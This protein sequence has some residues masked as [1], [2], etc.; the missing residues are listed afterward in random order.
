MADPQ[1]PRNPESDR[2]TS[3]GDAG[4]P[5][6]R[7]R[8]YRGY[9]NTPKGGDVHTGSGFGGA[10]SVSRSGNPLDQNIIS[11][12]TREDAEKE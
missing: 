6:R 5:K 4:R 10:G 2:A 12:R 9:P 11:E 1:T 7:K 3:G 8:G